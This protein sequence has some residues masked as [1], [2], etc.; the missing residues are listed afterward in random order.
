LPLP[1][2][3][4]GRQ[5]V[6]DNGIGM[7]GPTLRHLFTSFAQGEA[8]T[9]RRFGGTGLG[10]A[11][12]HRLVGSMRGLID[13]QSTEA[14]SPAFTVRL[15]IE[16][17]H[18]DRGHGPPKTPAGFARAS[19]VR[20]VL[21]TTGFDASPAWPGPNFVAVAVD[22]NGLSR[23][24]LLGAVSAAAGRV[25]LVRGDTDEEI[26]QAAARH[27]AVQVAACAHKLKSSSRPV[28][29][30]ALGDVCAALELAA[31]DSGPTK[32]TVRCIELETTM[33]VGMAHLAANTGAE[34]LSVR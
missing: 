16:I 7:S 1:G 32:V 8:S 14:A 21:L 33:A 20:K 10:L 30:L 31:I 13:V 29:A 17:A 6:T 11:I 27:D 18:Q 24:A 25:S 19:D 15:P 22:G 3:R 26:R 4:R 12:S 34:L 2:D 28:G 9:T 23:L 5:G